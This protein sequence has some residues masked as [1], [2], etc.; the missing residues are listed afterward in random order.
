[1]N[2]NFLHPSGI[3]AF[4]ISLAS[5]FDFNAYKMKDFAA[6]I[7]ATSIYRHPLTWSGKVTSLHITIP[8]S[9]NKLISHPTIPHL[10]STCLYL[11]HV[12]HHGSSSSSSSIP[13]LHTARWRDVLCCD[14]A[15]TFPPSAS[16]HVLTLPL[17]TVWHIY[18]LAAADHLDITSTFV[19]GSL[20]LCLSS[21]I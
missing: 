10:I 20:R 8:V 2:T 1:M 14:T 7:Q 12:S 4:H 17:T 18:P 11:M 16:I 21:Q 3:I 19:N 13:L 6:G 15:K 9:H 5:I